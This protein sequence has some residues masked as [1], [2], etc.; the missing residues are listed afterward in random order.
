[1]AP[2]VILCHDR[3]Y[4]PRLADL[5]F[6]KIMLS[7]L[8]TLTDDRD[9]WTLPIYFQGQSLHQ[10]FGLCVKR[11]R[12]ERAE[13][14]T[15]RHTHTEMDRWER[16]YTLDC[17]HGWPMC[18]HGRSYNLQG[19]AS[20]PK[21]RHCPRSS[22]GHHLT[23]KGSTGNDI[24]RPCFKRHWAPNG[25][26]SDGNDRALW[27]E[28]CLLLWPTGHAL[29]QVSKWSNTG[30]WPEV[31]LSPKHASWE[32]NLWSVKY[33]TP[34]VIKLTWWGVILMEYCS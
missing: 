16:F 19:T 9:H 17:W 31:C 23:V 29:S 21:M 7:D 2:P 25:R 13:W 20:E 10:I 4:Q 6:Q 15:D 14:Q 32:A 12:R 28:R 22:F 30:L 26:V 8:A 1:M 34:S 18:H 11:F 5:K 24:R 27:V 3:V 33:S